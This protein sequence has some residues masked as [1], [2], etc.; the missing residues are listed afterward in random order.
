[1]YKYF[2]KNNTYRYL[3]V[4]NNLL[5]GYKNSVHSTIGMPQSKVSHSNIY[6]VW[7]KVNILRAKIPHGCVEF[8]VG[9]LVKIT[10]QKVV[11]AKSYEQTFSTEIF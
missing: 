3:D 7:R 9:D 2:T 4:I 6:S 8:I 11:F 10:K 1:M 5:A